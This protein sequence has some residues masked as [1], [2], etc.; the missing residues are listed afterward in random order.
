MIDNYGYAQTE[1]ER[2]GHWTECRDGELIYS[3]K[4][5]IDSLL[6]NYDPLPSAKLDAISRINEQS[7]EL[8]QDIESAYPE[9]EKRT[10]PTQ[11]QEAEAW[12]EDSNCKTPLL[13]VIASS[14]GIDR[15]AL[16][17]KTVK[18]VSQY[19]TYAAHLAGTRQKLEGE[20]VNS[21]DLHFICTANFKV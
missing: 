12:T 8:M 6:N 9:F 15:I 2:C 10:W 19:N 14:R 13:D 18:K 1:I 5:A 3:D 16:L 11:K 21:V 4:T 20:I 17:N 7:Q